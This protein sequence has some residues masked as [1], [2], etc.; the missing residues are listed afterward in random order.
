MVIKEDAARYRRD[1][2]S[3]LVAS[4]IAQYGVDRKVD[5]SRT[6]DSDDPGVMQSA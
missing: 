4:S 3:S 2:A 6:V 5:N 1:S